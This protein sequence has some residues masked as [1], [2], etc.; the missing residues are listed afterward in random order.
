V[1]TTLGLILKMD[2]LPHAAVAPRTDNLEA[3]DDF[4]RAVEYGSRLTKDDIVKGREW[5]ERAIE[6][7]AAPAAG[8]GTRLASVA[9]NVMPGA[10]SQSASRYRVRFGLPRCSRAGRNHNRDRH[11]RPPY[12]FL[13]CSHASIL[14][15]CGAGFR[16]V[17]HEPSL[18]FVAP[19]FPG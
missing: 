9:V 7:E 1:V 13:G 16:R 2:R 12:G 14:F 17:R 19:I 18:C 15:L 3:F 6:L 4:L 11:E 5:A 8:W 10:D